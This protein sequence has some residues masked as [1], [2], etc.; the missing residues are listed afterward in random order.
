VSFE[1]PKKP[2]LKTFLTS[3]VFVLTCTAS[4]LTQQYLNF[5]PIH[6]Y[7]QGAVDELSMVKTK[8][9]D[10]GVN[11]SPRYSELKKEWLLKLQFEKGE[12]DKSLKFFHNEARFLYDFYQKGE[13]NSLELLGL[14]ME[15]M[16]Q[17]GLKVTEISEYLSYNTYPDNFI[18]NSEFF[19]G[20]LNSDGL[21]SVYQDGSG[22]GQINHI[23]G[24]LYL[25]PH[26]PDSTTISQV[27]LEIMKDDLD[28]SSIKAFL[29]SLNNKTIPG[30]NNHEQVED[31]FLNTV[32]KILIEKVESGEFEN[33]S[34]FFVWLFTNPPEELQEYFSKIENH[35]DNYPKINHQIFLTSSL[36]VAIFVYLWLQ[37]KENLEVDKDLK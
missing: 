18:S 24:V 14:L 22:G 30:T 26:W 31:L 12:G 8:Y 20:D 23:L 5:L 33:F 21:D 37:K 7:Q 16:L 3:T 32:I 1:K 13:I 10:S 9:L 29:E 17:I 19:V 2:W 35:W 28:F 25:F 36:A 6:K 34:D 27:S 15:K 4:I 11:F